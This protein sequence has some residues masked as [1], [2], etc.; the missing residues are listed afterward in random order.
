MSTFWSKLKVELRS[1]YTKV[2]PEQSTMDISTHCTLSGVYKPRHESTTP[3]F[4]IETIRRPVT[5]DQG[6]IQY[7]W[8]QLEMFS[9]DGL[10]HIACWDHFMFADITPEPEYLLD[11]FRLLS[12]IIWALI[13]ERQ[14]RHN[15]LLSDD[16]ATVAGLI[17]FFTAIKFSKWVFGNLSLF[18]LKFT[19][20]NFNSLPHR[21]WLFSP[22]FSLHLPLCTGSGETFFKK[23]H[24]KTLPSSIA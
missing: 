9:I 8:A 13:W 2:H 23:F 5:S 4:P 21:L 11:S 18:Q 17:F 20:F 3:R 14:E 24:S 7:M 12:G 16:P 6:H 19:F 22:W 15:A 1:I 10:F